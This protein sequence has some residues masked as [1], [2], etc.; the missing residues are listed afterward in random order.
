MNKFLQKLFRAYLCHH[1]FYCY[2]E[3]LMENIEQKNTALCDKCGLRLDFQLFV[4]H[5]SRNALTQYGN[6]LCGKNTYNTKKIAET[7]L[8]ICR[9]RRKGS[10]PIRSY[11]CH[12]CQGW[13][14]TKRA[15]HNPER[16][17]MASNP[18]QGNNN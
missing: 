17:E 2:V 14:L 8:N 10:Q 1:S 3:S 15:P 9:K 13:H 7:I 6:T 18:Q 16:N 11:R 12:K 5:V 4:D